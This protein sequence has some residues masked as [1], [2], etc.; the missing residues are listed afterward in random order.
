MDETI[1]Q[2]ENILDALE[3]TGGDPFGVIETSMSQIQT[4]LENFPESTFPYKFTNFKKRVSSW[5]NYSDMLN[6]TSIEQFELELIN[7]VS[8]FQTQFQPRQITNPFP[9]QWPGRYSIPRKISN[10]KTIEELEKFIS[11]PFP[12]S[13]TGRHSL[14]RQI[15]NA[16]TIEDLENY[17][18]R[19]LDPF[20]LSWSNSDELI[21]KGASLKLVN[22]PNILQ[23]EN[24]IMDLLKKYKF[25]WDRLD[26]VKHS[27][28]FSAKTYAELE[29]VITDLVLQCDNYENEYNQLVEDLNEKNAKAQRE[30][31]TLKQDAKD[32]VAIHADE[33]KA[34]KNDNQDVIERLNNNITTLSVQSRE[35][36]DEIAKLNA[37]ITNGTQQLVVGSHELD[38]KNRQISTLSTQFQE[39]MVVNQRVNEEL[40][41]YRL[42]EASERDMLGK[43]IQNY[44]E[45][46]RTNNETQKQLLQAQTQ[47]DELQKKMQSLLKRCS[48]DQDDAN[49]RR[50]VDPRSI[51]QSY[52]QADLNY[53]YAF[54]NLIFQA[55]ESTNIVSYFTN[56]PISPN[57]TLKDML[58]VEIRAITQ[59][60]VPYV[61]S[62]IP[63]QPNMDLIANITKTDFFKDYSVVRNVS[64]TL[65]FE[66]INELQTLTSH[67]NIID[68]CIDK[69][70]TSSLIIEEVE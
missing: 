33:I 56:H 64:Q 1:E 59:N 52:F 30:N 67:I 48:R 15:L 11:N 4:I 35:K 40:N 22:A 24:Q 53:N 58:L 62:Q 28:I 54:C 42:R 17:I 6:A 36:D 41:N 25:K 20:P 57:N 44:S 9:L 18:S 45:L 66:N 61:G 19:I 50:R 47:N 51:I 23:L 32:L 5:Q 46:E 13:W 65:S 27:E 68:E 49:K 31:T 38:F 37:I 26:P 7:F 3:S 16:N 8:S 12:L 14:P 10:A 21:R 29:R 2:I 60:V 34:L 43:A 70:Q 39:T 63:L 55:V 69:L